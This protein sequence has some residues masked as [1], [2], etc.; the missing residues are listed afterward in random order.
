M[1]PDE[2]EE[3]EGEEERNSKVEALVGL[4]DF[5]SDRAEAQASFLVACIFGIF[6]LL[7]IVQSINSIQDKMI[8]H[9]LIILSIFPYVMLSS[10][11]FHCLRRFSVYAATAEKYNIVLKR[12]AKPKEIM[13]KVKGKIKE[14]SLQDY[15]EYLS[16]KYKGIPKK[17]RRPRIMIMLYIFIFGLPAL[18][19]YLPK[20]IELAVYLLNS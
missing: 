10:I 9:A 13:I 19:V 17:F 12:Y 5:Y 7:A 14:M 6:T 11:G 18:F 20:L 15:E 16:E 3:V 1:S 4:L 2:N 8:Q